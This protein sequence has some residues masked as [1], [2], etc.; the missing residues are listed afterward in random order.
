MSK[1]A[2]EIKI[3]TDKIREIETDETYGV[4][5]IHFIIAWSLIPIHLVGVWFEFWSLSIIPF[6]LFFLY[7]VIMR[8]YKNIIMRIEINTLDLQIEIRLMNNDLIEE[9]SKSK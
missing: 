1:Y 6:V 2:N 7:V 9:L 4:S 8:V 5:N 3:L